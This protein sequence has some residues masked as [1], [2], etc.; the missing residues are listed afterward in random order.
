MCTYHNFA[1]ASANDLR[2]PAQ[3]CVKLGFAN[4]FAN[5]Y[6]KYNYIYIFFY[7]YIY[8]YINC[9]ILKTCMYIYIYVYI[10]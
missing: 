7:I 4:G 2:R 1:E 3:P 10:L 8:T 9:K 5:M 6:N